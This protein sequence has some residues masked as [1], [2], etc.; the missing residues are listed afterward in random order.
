[1]N[2]TVNPFGKTEVMQLKPA[3][4]ALVE[5]EQ[6]RAIAEAQAS[7]IIAKRF[8]RNQIECMDNI[9]NACSRQSLAESALYSYARGGTNITGPSIRLA[10]AIAQSWHNISY[11]IRELEQREGVSTMEAFAWDMETNVKQVKIFQVAHKRYTRK[12]SYALEDPRDI[13]EMVANQGA[14]RLRACI[15]GVIPGDVV[16]AAV[17]QCNVTLKTKAAVT[18]ERI[19]SLVEKFSEFGVT[20]TQIEKRIQRRIDAITPAL[21]VSLGKIYNSLKDGMSA[22]V[23]WFEAGVDISAIVP[24]EKKTKKKADLTKPIL[25]TY[26]NALESVQAIH[27]TSNTTESPLEAYHKLSQSDPE[28]ML[29]ALDELGYSDAETDEQAG[30][31]IARYTELKS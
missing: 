2:E 20:K 9:L 15:L 16:E 28:R 12:G 11:G 14:R 22:P 25:E 27:A 5:V 30:Q 6:S 1:M 18:P 10:E 21:M 19:Q 7:I 26:G 31:V 17:E 4:Q 13:Y 23:D 24:E 29:A 8:P 3:N